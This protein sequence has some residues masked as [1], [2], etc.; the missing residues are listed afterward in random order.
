MSEHDTLKILVALVV[1]IGLYAAYYYYEFGQWCNAMWAGTLPPVFILLSSSTLYRI[2][3]SYELFQE[4]KRRREDDKNSD[5]KTPRKNIYRRDN[6]Q[7][8]F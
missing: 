4:R 8:R 5:P 7:T 2:L 6:N 3:K 1:S